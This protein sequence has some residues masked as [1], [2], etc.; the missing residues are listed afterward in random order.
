MIQVIYLD[1]PSLLKDEP[2]ETNSIII[3]SEL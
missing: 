1:H 3:T 2:T